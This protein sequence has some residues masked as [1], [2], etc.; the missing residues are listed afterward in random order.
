MQSELA[1][2]SVGATVLLLAACGEP[3]PQLGPPTSPTLRPAT[4][5]EVQHIAVVWHDYCFGNS[6]YSREKF[7]DRIHFTYYGVGPFR[8]TYYVSE[9]VL[10]TR[11]GGSADRC[12]ALF[13]GPDGPVVQVGDRRDE[14]HGTE[15]VCC[16]PDQTMYPDG[17]FKRGPNGSVLRA[18]E[19]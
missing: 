5:E 3:E 1:F 18:P 12:R 11:R 19:P 8:G 2:L 9:N 16:R 4:T 14:G 10:C 13:I 6:I 7:H 17:R 15:W